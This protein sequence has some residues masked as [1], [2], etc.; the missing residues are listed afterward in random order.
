MT[1]P[2]LLAMPDSDLAP[3]TEGALVEV[4][5]KKDDLRTSAIVQRLFEIA[6]FRQGYQ[7]AVNAEEGGRDFD[8]IVRL[9]GGRPIV[10][11]IKTAWWSPKQ[12]H[13]AIKNKSNSHG[14]YSAE[15]YDVLAVYLPDRNQWLFYTRSE[16]GN[17]GATCYMP[18]EFR[19]KAP[20]T[21]YGIHGETMDDRDP[22]NWDLLYRIAAPKPQ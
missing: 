6:A 19:K 5:P 16:L 20:A 9:P 22:D 17:R 10:I 21:T 3:V 15:A 2:L 8:A 1:Q 13:Y 4:A 18:R 12:S 7:I 14:V 11:Q